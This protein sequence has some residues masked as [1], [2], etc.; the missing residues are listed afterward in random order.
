MLVGNYLILCLIVGLTSVCFVLFVLVWLEVLVVCGY[1]II[2]VG[3]LVL[4]RFIL[5]DYLLFF[6]VFVVGI[7]RFVV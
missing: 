4:L 3:L 7:C 2:V 1:V 5:V 6:V